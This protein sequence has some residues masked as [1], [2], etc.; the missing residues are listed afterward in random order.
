MDR[1]KPFESKQPGTAYG[2]GLEVVVVVD[3]LEFGGLEAVV[4]FVLVFVVSFVFS[5]TTVDAGLTT[6]VLLSVFLSAGGLTVSLFCS[7]PPRSAA[8]AK[9][10]TSFFIFGFGCPSW[11][12]L[13]RNKLC[14]RPCRRQVCF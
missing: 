4:V 8:L 1:G 12:N 3:V 2:L 14:N 13:I 9:M 5:F 7:Q 6:V 10:Q 11:T